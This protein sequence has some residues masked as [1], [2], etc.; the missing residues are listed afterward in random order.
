[1]TPRVS[2]LIPSYNHGRFLGACLDSLRSQ[3]FTDWEAILVDDG[4]S[5]DSIAVAQSYG[6]PR[7]SIDQNPTNLGTY[8]TLARA[9]GLS[10]APL[11]AVLNS[12][13]LWDRKKLELQVESLDSNPQISICYTLGR[14][15]DFEGRI[16]HEDVHAPWPTD[17][18]QETLPFLLSENRVLASSVVYRREAV[19]FDSSLRFSGDWVSL[20]KPAW[21]SPFACVPQNLTQWRMHAS[22]TFVRSPGQIAEEIRVREAI[23]LTGAAWETDRIPSRDIKRGLGKCALHLS[24]LYVLQGRMTD[25]RKASL[26]S[27]KL[28]RG[29]ESLRRLAAVSMPKNFAQ[30]RLWPGE[31]TVPASTSDELKL[32]G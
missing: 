4:S 29:K 26:M 3:T 25:A 8:G 11:I 10:K 17:L 24:A 28:S 7:L 14:R 20:L 13:D 23:L 2:V 21:Q 18:V 12:D 22:N 27:V 31:A 15:I 16:N 30:K 1:M 6:D 5:D 32:L 19:R 9:L